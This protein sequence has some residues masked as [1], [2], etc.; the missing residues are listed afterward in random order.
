MTARFN[1]SQAALTT[2]TPSICWSST[3][4]GNPGQPPVRKWFIVNF[5][6]TSGS[7]ILLLA[8]TPSEVG[9]ISRL[10]PSHIHKHRHSPTAKQSKCRRKRKQNGTTGASAWNGALA[11]APPILDALVRRPCDRSALLGSSEGQLCIRTTGN[12]CRLGIRCYAHQH[13]KLENLLNV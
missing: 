4:D 1:S 13:Y 3:S 8:N 6:G 9:Q 10:E 7:S 12:L 5:S 2:T 11:R